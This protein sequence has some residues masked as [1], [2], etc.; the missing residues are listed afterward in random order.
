[1]QTEFQFNRDG[2]TVKRQAPREVIDAPARFALLLTEQAA[3]AGFSEPCQIFSGEVFRA[4]NGTVRPRRF[5][6]SLRGIEAPPGARF[7]VKC[8]TPGCVR[9]VEV[10]Q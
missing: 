1:M 10:K 9:H 7:T 6:L 4:D 8:K 3:P 2:L 5:A